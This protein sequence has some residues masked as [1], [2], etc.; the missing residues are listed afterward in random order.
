MASSPAQARRP[1]L[2]GDAL[3]Y[4]WRSVLLLIIL[5][6]TMGAALTLRSA[7]TST[8]TAAVIVNPLLGNPFSPDGSDDL[9]AMSTEAQVVRSDDVAQ[10]AATAVG[11]DA[12]SLPAVTVTVVPNT[13]VLEIT[14]T[15]QDGELAQDVAD[16]F[17]RSYLDLRTQLALD[18][19]GD[20]TQRLE[21][22]IR[23]SEDQLRAATRRANAATS[24]GEEALQNRLADGFQ[25]DVFNQR[26]ALTEVINTDTTSGRVVSPA[27]TPTTRSA[28]KFLP[29]AGGLIAGLLAGLAFALLRERSQDLVRSGVAVSDVG[30]RILG[31]FTRGMRSKPDQLS[32]AMRVTRLHALET[33][34]TSAVLMV[35]DPAP[36]PDTS[37]LAGGLA[38]AF[39][40][41]PSTV[42]LVQ[43]TDVELLGTSTA[44]LGGVD[45]L[46]EALLSEEDAVAMLLP[47]EASLSYLPPGR[48]LAQAYERFLP[49]FLGPVLDDLSKEDRLVV[50]QSPPLSSAE[51]EALAG[52]ADAV[53]LV[54]TR[55]RHRL[56]DVERT[57]ALLADRPAQL[58]GAVIVDPKQA[59]LDEWGPGNASKRHSRD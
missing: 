16:Q 51:G 3:R 10:A 15:A 35:A 57:A 21:D 56:A 19:V 27:S 1:Y 47:V 37:R 6:G 52:A 50:V 38:L 18:V 17:A 31:E 8:S 40:R 45:G 41:G 54:I 26:S 30:V 20:R 7:D 49:E 28:G 32:E 55:H 36:P 29:L 44:G 22:Q 4:R 53:L 43:A 14:A 42:A 33:L 13:Q 11:Q 24:S 48:N 34:G 39:A 25:T 46:S 59:R 23:E 2:V 5:G 9:E 12:D 58:I